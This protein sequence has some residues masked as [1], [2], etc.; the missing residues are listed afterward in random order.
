MGGRGMND[1]QIKN[2]V[3]PL[4]PTAW[5]TVL[6]QGSVRPHLNRALSSSIWLPETSLFPVIHPSWRSSMGV[7]GVERTR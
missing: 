4:E 1:M 3:N 5:P 7:G 2:H 6:S